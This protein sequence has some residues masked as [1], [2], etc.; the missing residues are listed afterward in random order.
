MTPDERITL[1]CDPILKLVDAVDLLERRLNAM[2]KLEAGG[3][4]TEDLKNALSI[5]LSI[6]RS[7]LFRAEKR[8]AQLEA[9]VEKLEMEAEAAMDNEV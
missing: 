2:E 3:Q 5:A 7:K 8:V 1:L 9:Q 6:E 4:A